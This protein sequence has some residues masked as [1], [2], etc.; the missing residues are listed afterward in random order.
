MQILSVVF[1]V[2]ALPWLG[3]MAKAQEAAETFTQSSERWGETT[4][5]VF[6]NRI[7]IVIKE[8]LTF[9]ERQRVVE[10][11]DLVID[12]ADQDTF[13]IVVEA[14]SPT[15]RYAELRRQAARLRTS[16]ELISWAGPV[17]VVGEVSNIDE[18][19]TRD[20]R[21][22]TNVLTVKAR[23]GV[24]SDTLL[25]FA[26]NLGLNLIQRNP[27]DK[28][29][30]FFE[31]VAHEGDQHVFTSMRELSNADLHEY[32]TVDTIHAQGVL[33]GQVA[34]NDAHF[35]MQWTLVNTGQNGG[36]PDADID[37][38]KALRLSNA[39]IGSEQGSDQSTAIIAMIDDGFDMGHPDL[40][41]NLLPGWDFGDCENDPD[42]IADALRGNVC[43]DSNPG[44]PGNP[45]A[46]HGTMTAGAAAA[47]G[48]NTIGI[49]GSCPT[50]SLLPLKVR[51][52]GYSH[53][54]FTLAV[55][56]AQLAD[57][58]IINMSLGLTINSEAASLVN[59]IENATQSGIAI[60]VA[61]STTGNGYRDDCAANDLSSLE[62]VIAISA[63]NNVD[64]RTPSGYGDCMAVL[65]P[66][67]HEGATDEEGNTVGTLWPMS[68][69]RLGR[70]GYNSE[71]HPSN[72]S[73]SELVDLSYS[74]CANGTSYAA[75]LVA[76]VAG[77]MKS[78]NG[79]LTPQRIR[80]LLQD[81]ADKIDPDAA[82]YD[83]NTGFSDLFGYGRVN[84]YEGMKVLGRKAVG[85]HE[86]VDLFLRDSE[87]DWGN[88]EQPSNLRMG[89]PRTVVLEQQSPAIKIDAPPFEPVAPITFE[90]FEDFDDEEPHA[91]T[92]NRVYVL[93][94][95][96]GGNIATDVRI[97]LAVGASSMPMPQAF[98]N[99]SSPEQYPEA[100]WTAV[101][102][103]AIASIGYS[104]AS[105][106]TRPGDGARVAAL[107][108]D[109]PAIELSRSETRDF[110]LVA[111]VYSA[112]D[113]VLDHSMVMAAP[114]QIAPQDNNI[115]VRN[116]RLRKLH[117]Q[118]KNQ[119]KD[120]K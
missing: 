18:V 19:D 111:V 45:S 119:Y 65:A 58:D 68:T 12:K 97:K 42:T 56:Y 64:T 78:V 55:I 4:Y 15:Q 8:G 10:Q 62:S 16:N 100:G 34:V 70:D 46:R 33:R 54:Q 57:A 118:S 81:T 20:L 82:D 101:A 114:H 120:M 84:Q 60:F 25:D 3:G 110:T 74:F 69:D 99:D 112:D 48:N 87:F 22:P 1:M 35:D 67:D 61:M 38:D 41:R 83:H 66:T 40:V 104:G 21:V 53:Y 2:A 43:G 108:F 52:E 29:E 13:V 73:S 109:A 30:Y 89:N 24:D 59:N 80:Q 94:R 31:Q 63:S 96:R 76:G 98:W 44:T 85:G 79:A 90:A 113:P 11:A 93:V 14:P 95:N 116:I 23:E 49:T 71:H 91:A 103:G 17:V 32:I 115:T 9:E 28:R 88:T 6:A 26:E 47:V 36:L 5:T 106:A 107:D 92:T 7:G 51:T 50:C 86:D 75:P 117:I 77:L 72:C 27:V 37:F 102:T 39:L 105:I